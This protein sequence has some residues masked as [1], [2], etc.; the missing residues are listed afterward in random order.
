M[1][2]AFTDRPVPRPLVDRVIDAGLRAPS[3][4]FTQGTSFVVLEGPSTARFWE[5]TARTPDAPPP[6]GRLAGMRAAPV[7]VVPLAHK[8]AYLERYAEPDKEHLGR[9]REQAW[10]VPYWDI[11]AAFAV[12]AM[13]LA[14]TDAGLGAVF[15]GLFHG[16]AAVLAEF[17]VPDGHRPIGAIALGWP[18][19][20]DHRSP[21]LDRGRRP[22]AEIVH[23]GRWSGR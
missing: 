10:P 20:R 19:A 17:G 22:R 6:G 3:A 1:V 23:Y 14:A 4:G 15:F 11:D 16:E 2:R 9:A 21:S 8:A 13:L 5:L 18:S 7:V 12:M